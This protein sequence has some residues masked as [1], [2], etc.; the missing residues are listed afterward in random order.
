ME[1][2]RRRAAGQDAG[3][4]G[5]GGAGEPAGISPPAV[6]DGW[7]AA[8]PDFVGV[9]AQRSGTTW[10]YEVIASHPGVTIPPGRP[11]ELHFFDR[12]CRVANVP[13]D[14]YHRYFPR[15][16][17]QLC[18]EW[19]PRYMY[20]YWTP[21]MLRRAAPRAK[22]LV[23]LRDPVERFLSGLAM[24]LSF[25]FELNSRVYHQFWRGSYWSQLRTLLEYFDRSQL[26]VL[27]YEQCVADPAAQARRTF[28]FLGLD[29]AVTVE[30]AQF[31]R[32]VSQTRARKPAIDGATLS[33]LRRSYQAELGQL[34]AEF[35]EL[36][37]SLWPS[38]G[39]A[40]PRSVSGGV[41]GGVRG[42][43]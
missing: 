16:P 31:T 28:G 10:W 23:M 39:D 42:D 27:Q 37:S 4:G 34:F 12:Y 8:P 20:D 35:P 3:T 15:P 43:G 14:S 25:G 11:K 1:P 19:T 5:I 13:A 33:A 38:F 36:D 40:C 41:S 29:P 9:G 24:H 6:P 22:V 18:G 2:V 7:R 30:P 21:P 26:L 17:G 32:R